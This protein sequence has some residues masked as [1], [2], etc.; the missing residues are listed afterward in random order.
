ME[1][2][3]ALGKVRQYLPHNAGDYTTHAVVFVVYNSFHC[4]CTCNCIYMYKYTYN[5]PA[6]SRNV[7]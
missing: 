7:G 1:E 6:N 5:L 2:H 3:T 4:T